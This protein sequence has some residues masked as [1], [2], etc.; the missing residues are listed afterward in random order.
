M[1]MCLCKC[2]G[3]YLIKESGASFVHIGVVWLD[4]NKSIQKL[5]KKKSKRVCIKILIN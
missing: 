2:V 1:F 4:V 5:W 3:A